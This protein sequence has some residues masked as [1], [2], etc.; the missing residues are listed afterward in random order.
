MSSKSDWSNISVCQFRK[1][2]WEIFFHVSMVTYFSTSII[3]YWVL[4]FFISFHH[5][6]NIFY[7]TEYKTGNFITNENR[8]LAYKVIAFVEWQPTL[9]YW[10]INFFFFSC[11]AE[12]KSCS[13]FS[14]Y[15]GAVKIPLTITFDICC[16]LLIACAILWTLFD[17]FIAS[18]T[19]HSLVHLKMFVFLSVYFSASP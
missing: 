2:S 1:C 12:M 18:L 19:I 4:L 10:N 8:S 13:T 6:P 16:N 3:E 9:S 11:S 15:L 5:S 7:V 14:W 17:G